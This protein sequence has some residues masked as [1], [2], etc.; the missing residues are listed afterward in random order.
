ML[1]FSYKLEKYIKHKI[2]PKML[3]DVK[4][5]SIKGSFR[6]KIPYVTDIDVVNIVYPTYNRS[7]IQEAILKLIDSLNESSNQNIILLSMLCGNDNRFILKSCEQCEIDR[8]K[9]LLGIRDQE[10]IDLILKKYHDDLNRKMFYLLELLRPMY[11][12]KWKKSD[13]MRGEIDHYGINF[14]FSNVLSKNT[15]ILLQYYVKI[16]SDILG[17]DIVINYEPMNMEKAYQEAADYQ[18]KLANYSDEYYYMMFPFR[19]YFR[20]KPDI[21]QEIEDIIEKKFGIYKQIMV[22]IDTYDRLYRSEMLDYQTA[23]NIV[24]NLISAIQRLPGNPNLPINNFSNILNQLKN[25]YGE[26]DENLRII[27]W[28]ILMNIVYDEIN[29][30]LS[31]I[32]KP[33]FFKYLEMVDEADRSKFYLQNSEKP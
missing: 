23:S 29:I 21:R 31:A 32:S 22:R 16:N 14:K 11:K 26:P 10:K 1:V 3:L 17:I 8:I 25:V 30:T 7:N 18:I 28:S 15:S 6:R 12:L 19:Y 4:N 13:I 33:Y 2:L 9:K 5:Y 24:K 27:H 20:N